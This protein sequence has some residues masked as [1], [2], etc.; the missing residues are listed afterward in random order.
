VVART[1]KGKGARA[2]EN[3]DGEHGMPVEDPDGAVAELGG[4]RDIRVEVPKP[5]D[6]GKPHAFEVGPLELPRCESGEEVAMRKAYG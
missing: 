5:A 2:V 1:I 3:Q 4:V 6:D